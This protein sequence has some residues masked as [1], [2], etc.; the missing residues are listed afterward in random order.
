MQSLRVSVIIF[1]PGAILPVSRVVGL[2]DVFLKRKPVNEGC[3]SFYDFY[4]DWGQY[5][6][7]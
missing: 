6:T 2:E 7:K 5:E 3:R 1:F 4:K